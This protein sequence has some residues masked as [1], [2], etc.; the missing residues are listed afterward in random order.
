MKTRG[1]VK[2]GHLLLRLFSWFV[3]SSFYV[4]SIIKI[5]IAIFKVPPEFEMIFTLEVHGLQFFY[6]VIS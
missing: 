3:R 4:W 2:G 6:T 5:G 1:K